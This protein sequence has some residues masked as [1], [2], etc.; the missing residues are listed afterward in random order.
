MCGAATAAP[1]DAAGALMWNPAS[2]SGL[3]TSE[4]DLGLELF[5]PSEKLSSSF[6]AY[7]MQG[8]TGGEPGVMPIP[9]LAFVHKCED[10]PWAWGVGVFGIAGFSTNYPAS[11][12][13]P[14]L[15]PQPPNG[16]GLG[17]VSSLAEYYQV[18]PTV[19]VAVTDRISVGLAPT[20]TIA[21]LD[22]N[23]MVFA[24]P[25]NASGS[26]YFNYPAS[27][28]T[29]Y[30]FG[31]GFQVGVFFKPTETWN[32]GF[33]FKSPQWFE[34][35]TF[36]T[37]D[38]LGR[39]EVASAHFDYPLILSLGTAYTG[40]ENWL[41]ACDVRYYD[42]A[43]TAGFG[44]PAAFAPNGAVL[45]LGWNSV[46]SVHAGTQY[47]VTDRLTLRLGY[48]FSPSPIDSDTAFFNIASPLIIE[49]I[50]GTGFSYRLTNHEIVSV[51]Y[52]HGFQNESTGPIQ[53]PGLGAIPGTSVSSA[54]SADALAA[55]LTIQY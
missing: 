22:V 14:V 35:G 48:E 47:Y 26:G 13:N 40:L 16:L 18:V 33:S 7:G 28:G 39:P 37:T 5:L 24:P 8:S 9:E 53:T 46:V 23:P 51:A 41:F 2:I 17:R 50:I 27:D 34:T 20:L 30:H 52:L 10:S 38:E 15:T 29:R 31:G 55:G 11:L 54:I 49:H 36:N 1:I 4:V 44:S 42:Y 21:R 25:D 43:R 45:G 12:T 6:A 19:S 32:L 3:S